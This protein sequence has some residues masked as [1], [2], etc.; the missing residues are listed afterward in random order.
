MWLL[1][2]NS[3]DFF[4][5]SMLREI[6]SGYKVGL[7]I[8]RFMKNIL[9]VHLGFSE[10]LPSL[11]SQR[12]IITLPWLGQMAQVLSKQLVPH[13]I[14]LQW[15]PSFNN[16]CTHIHVHTHTH[17]HTHTHAQAYRQHF[18]TSF[19][20]FPNRTLY[21]KYPLTQI[22]KLPSFCYVCFICSYSCLLK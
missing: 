22:Q 10:L 17:T 20:H 8:V 4:P 6:L 2:T 7:E 11:T 1:K 12:L 3:A 19:I 13:L 21:N 18:S 15:S 5:L 14:S 9:K 16:Y